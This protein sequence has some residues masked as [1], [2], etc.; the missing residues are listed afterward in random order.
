MSDTTQTQTLEQTLNKTDF[1]HIIYE[2]RK[3][4]F[5]IL[6]AILVSVTGYVLWK[7]SQK[8][9]AE[10]ISVQVFDFQTKTWA[11]A[12]EGK[13]ATAELVKVFEGLDKDV[14]MS[15]V[16]VPLALEIG[17]FLFDKGALNEAEAI[18]SKVNTNH[19]V[20]AF[21]VGTQRAVILEKLNKIP[22]AIAVLEKLAQDKEAFLAAKINLELGRLNLMNGEKGKAQTH[23]EY[24]IN[25]FPNDE[26]AKLAKLYM[27]KLAQ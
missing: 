10:T 1:G 18:L 7:Q 9:Q 13:V 23:F 21:F 6:V 27:G 20:S 3:T 5:A 12:K 24:V 11:G 25:T 15:P 17:K 22:E 2:N 4:I 19:V 16:M 8:S 14:Q 26:Q